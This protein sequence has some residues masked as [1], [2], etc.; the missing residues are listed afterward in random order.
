MGE[1]PPHL[2]IAKSGFGGRSSD[3]GERPPQLALGGFC[4]TAVVLLGSANDRPKSTLFDLTLG[5]CSAPS[6]RTT[7]DRS[8]S[9]LCWAK[10]GGR[11]APVGRTTGDRSVELEFLL[12]WAVDRPNMGERPALVLLVDFILASKSLIFVLSASISVLLIN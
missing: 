2:I 1:R 9:F 8:V 4:H 12:F 6:G 11:P 5:D 3:L 7:G 10:L